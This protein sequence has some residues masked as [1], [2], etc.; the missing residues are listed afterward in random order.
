MTKLIREKSLNILEWDAAGRSI[1]VLGFLFFIYAQ[2]LIWSIY[3]VNFNKDNSL[4]NLAYLNKLIYVECMVLFICSCIIVT[5]FFLRKKLSTSLIFQH[6][7]LHF[8]SWSMLILAY[9]FGTLS[10]TVGMILIGA[11]LLS[12]ILLDRIAVWIAAGMFI[13]VITTLTYAS[14]AGIIRYA[15]LLASDFIADQAM[16]WTN[17]SYFLSLPFLI[18]NMLVIDRLLVSWRTREKLIKE[19][20]IT[21]GLTGLLNR[22]EILNN[23]DL[24]FSLSKRKN[25]P[26]SLIIL[27]LD[28]FKKVNDTYG[29]PIGD[30]VLREAA[31][32]LNMSI[33]SEDQLGRYGG[34]EFVIL[35][36]E[37]TLSEACNVAERCRAAL[38]RATVCLDDGKLLSFTASFGLVSC[39]VQLLNHPDELIRKADE[40]LYKAKSDGRNQVVS[41]SWD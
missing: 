8:F 7:A 10:Y 41:V 27:D 21:D 1:F 26:V 33:R 15:P 6:I 39:S 17:T 31:R 4:I 2:T 28:F 3:S 18:I 30:A 19:L 16:F 12:F 9:S 34:E 32:V 24:L 22:R 11:P 40:A 14:S 5:G 37:T 35:L 23:L 36:P 20:A 38:S 13:V 29:H 25:S